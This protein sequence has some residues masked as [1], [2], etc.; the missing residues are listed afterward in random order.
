MRGFSEIA[1]STSISD[2]VAAGSSPR[3][4]SGATSSWNRASSSAVCR[5]RAVQSIR[6]SRRLFSGWRCAKM[7]SATERFGQRLRSWKTT[8]MPWRADACA[9][10]N[11]TGAPPSRITPWSGW[12]TPAS[13]LII[14]LLPAPFSPTS[15]WI[16]PARSSKS[17]PS[18]ART[19][20]KD[21]VSP[22]TSSASPANSD[23][24]ETMAKLLLAEEVSV[25][26]FVDD[27]GPGVDRRGHA[28]DAGGRIV[29]GN[30]HRAIGQ[31]E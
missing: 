19:P 15:A 8:P 10:A 12:C 24:G 4:C 11:R 23:A 31:V 28:A 22:R 21:F 13:T 7:F 6:S 2:C 27:D 17:T 26:A 20:G 29:A 1:L 18:S 3:S 30:R 16:S 9:S 25:V 14:V 5:C